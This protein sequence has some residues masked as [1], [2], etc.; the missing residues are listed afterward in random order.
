MK[1]QCIGMFAAAGTCFVF[2]GAWP[3]NPANAQAYWGYGVGYQGQGWQ[4]NDY[5]YG[6][7]KHITL[8]TSKGLVTH[9]PT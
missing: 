7:I 9:K 5:G 8:G 3:V 1:I 4:E 6:Y 2:S